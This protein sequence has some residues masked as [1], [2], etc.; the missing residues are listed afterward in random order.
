MHCSLVAGLLVILVSYGEVKMMLWTCRARLEVG[1]CNM[2]TIH[3][4]QYLQYPAV[5]RH[6]THSP[7]LLPRL[8]FVAWNYR[9]LEWSACYLV[10]DSTAPGHR[11]RDHAMPPGITPPMHHGSMPKT[12]PPRSRFLPQHPLYC[13][14][15]HYISLHSTSLAGAALPP[16]VHNIGASRRLNN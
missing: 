12:R 5:H 9:G 1:S 6:Q 14:R 3:S 2:S 15:L 16:V 13:V 7:L 8:G 10:A 11:R 4:T